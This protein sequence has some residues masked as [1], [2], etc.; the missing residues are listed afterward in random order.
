MTVT[1]FSVFTSQPFCPIEVEAPADA[2]CR[3][4]ESEGVVNSRRISLVN[5]GVF[6]VLKLMR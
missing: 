2:V 1:A 3:D 6:F 5:R 4:D